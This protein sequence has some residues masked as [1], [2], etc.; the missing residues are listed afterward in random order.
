MLVYALACTGTADDSVPKTLPPADT[1]VVDTAPDSF[2][3]D[4]SLGDTGGDLTPAHTLTLRHEGTWLL[5]PSGGPW[6]AMTGTLVVTEELDGDTETPACAVTWSLTGEE[7]DDICEGC[8]VSFVIHHYVSEGDVSTCQEPDLPADGEDRTFGWS[9]GDQTI[10]YDVG[11]AGVWEPWYTADRV[12]DEL[13]FSWESQVGVAV[14]TG[15]G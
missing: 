1:G 5:S 6:T 15:E 10:Y 11:G 3:V 12:G 8:T 9:A 7:A 2:V 4:T 13:D 14:D